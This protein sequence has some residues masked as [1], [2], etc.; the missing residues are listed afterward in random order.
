[1]DVVL[2]M[3]GHG[4]CWRSEKPLNTVCMALERCSTMLEGCVVSEYSTLGGRL[5]SLS[6][7]NI[8][9]PYNNPCQDLGPLK[10]I[11]YRGGTV[12]R[13]RHG[14]VLAACVSDLVD[15]V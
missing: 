8:N 2:L 13:S 3:V 14:E 4:E 11:P 15:T 9:R 10:R 6:P 5:C 1:M 12:L 7:S